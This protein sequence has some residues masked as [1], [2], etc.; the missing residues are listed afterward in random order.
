MKNLIIYFYNINPKSIRYGKSGYFFSDEYNDYI[1]REGT[2]KKEEIYELIDLTDYLKQFGVYLHEFVVNNF[3]DVYSFVNTKYYVLLKIIKK[4]SR[5]IDISDIND[6]TKLEIKKKYSYITRNN[7]KKFWSENMDYIESILTEYQYV[8]GNIL[9][10]IDYNIG[11]VENAIQLLDEVENKGNSVCHIR[12]NKKTKAIDF[13]DPCNIVL[14]SKSRDY[15]EYYYDSIEENNMVLEGIVFKNLDVIEQKLFFIRMLY[16]TKFFDALS[17][18]ENQYQSDRKSMAKY[19]KI[20]NYISE[21]ENKIKLLYN[22]YFEKLL[23]KIEW[24]KK[25]S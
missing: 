2:R 7:W 13:Y 3:G 15:C 8:D 17:L 24:L 23:P 16:N 9:A 1:L 12:V 11:L 10:Y 6:L 21:Y 19:K 5:R 22:E 14:D 4:E 18:F 20:I 25:A